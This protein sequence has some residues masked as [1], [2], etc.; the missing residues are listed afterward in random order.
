[1]ITLAI[2]NVRV[3]L[4]FYCG[5]CALYLRGNKSFGITMKEGKAGG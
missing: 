5:E 3:Y 1:M 4:T 2:F